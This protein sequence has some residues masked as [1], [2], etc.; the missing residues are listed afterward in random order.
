MPTEKVPRE[1]WIEFLDEFS[2]RHE[3]WR[4]SLEVL[5]LEVG[6]Q[7]EVRDMPLRGITADRNGISVFLGGARDLGLEKL[8]ARPAELWVRTTEQGADESLEIRV[9]DG[10]AILLRFRAAVSPEQLNGVTS[11]L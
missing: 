3:G 1:R 6:A 5:G 4:V 9:E 2:R 10:N 7:T 8:I 11:E